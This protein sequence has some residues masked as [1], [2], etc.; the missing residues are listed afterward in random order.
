MT[1]AEP[2]FLLPLLHSTVIQLDNS[3]EG[4][5]VS[6]ALELAASIFS[7]SLFLVA[8]YAW[9]RRGRQPSLLIVSFAFLTFFVRQILE[10]IPLNFLH[11]EIVSSILDLLTLG[12]FFMAI[13]VTPRRKRGEVIEATMKK[14]VQGSTPE[15]EGE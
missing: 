15:S 1:I 5:L 11:N 2:S 13:V 9:T 7:F 3:F 6:D 8:L 4:G 12:L 10:V 14:E